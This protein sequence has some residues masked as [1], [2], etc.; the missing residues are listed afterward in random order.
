MAF[1]QRRLDP[2]THLPDGKDEIVAP[3][4]HEAVDLGRPRDVQ[5]ATRRLFHNFRGDVPDLNFRTI[6]EDEG[7]VQ[8]Q[9]HQKERAGRKLCALQRYVRLYYIHICSYDHTPLS[10]L[11]LCAS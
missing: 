1:E 10:P 3:L 7:E 9:G 11:V 2:R 4:P 8:Q 6:S 5:M